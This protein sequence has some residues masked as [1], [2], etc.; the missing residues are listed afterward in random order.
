MLFARSIRR[1]IAYGL[2]L[3]DE[4]TLTRNGD[5]GEMNS[6]AAE[7]VNADPNSPLLVSIPETE[8]ESA[9]AGAPLT[10]VRMAHIREAAEAANAHAFIEEMRDGYDTHVGERGTTIS[11]IG[12]SCTFS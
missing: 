8:P 5:A 12:L 4:D 10:R 9:G 2:E 11:G 6:G 1:N 7:S 3:V